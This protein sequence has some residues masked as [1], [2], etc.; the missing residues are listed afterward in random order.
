MLSLN[1]RGHYQFNV[2]V[3]CIVF[4]GVGVLLR[5]VSKWIHKQKTHVDDYWILVSLLSY[6]AAVGFCIW[7]GYY[8]TP[9]LV[10]MTQ[11]YRAHYGWRWNGD[12]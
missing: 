1:P 4:A 10:V 7:G 9:Q 8:S 5:G 12:R 6:W 11:N 2:K 3:I